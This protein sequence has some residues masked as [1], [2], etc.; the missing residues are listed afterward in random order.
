MWDKM[1]T[2][3]YLFTIKVNN[4]NTNSLISSYLDMSP[5]NVTR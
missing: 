5:T 2:G 4:Q 3:R 1:G